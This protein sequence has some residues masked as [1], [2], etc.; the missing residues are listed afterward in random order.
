MYEALIMSIREA[1]GTGLVLVG[2]TGVGYQA[3]TVLDYERLSNES[4]LRAPP[5]YSIRHKIDFLG[6]PSQ[7]LSDPVKLEQ[8][9]FL[10]N[11]YTELTK[12]DGINDAV[13]KAADYESLI[14]M[15]MF[16]GIFFLGVAAVGRVMIKGRG[17]TTS[18]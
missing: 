1:V 12:R 17:L 11:E 13:K 10:R 6:S 3:K 7:I 4:H 18:E 15:N 8:F 2:I 5:V 16:G 14:E 9:D